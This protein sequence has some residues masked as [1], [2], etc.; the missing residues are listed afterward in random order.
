MIANARRKRSRGRTTKILRSLRC[1]NENRTSFANHRSDQN[2]T[3]SIGCI[4]ELRPAISAGKLDGH[5]IIRVKALNEGASVVADDKASPAR[6]LATQARQERLAGRPIE[7]HNR[8]PD[9]GL[10][11]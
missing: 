11:P 1:P 8:G 4:R 3:I 2:L 10:D 5:G 7:N 9:I 6:G